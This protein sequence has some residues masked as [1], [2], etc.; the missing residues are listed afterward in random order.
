MNDHLYGRAE[1]SR[2]EGEGKGEERVC[3]ARGRVCW[4]EPN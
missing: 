2:L 4:S 1:Q 3:K